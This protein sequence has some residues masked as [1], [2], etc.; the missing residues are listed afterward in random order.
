MCSFSSPRLLASLVSSSCS[1]LA[2]SFSSIPHPLSLFYSKV[3]L[4]PKECTTSSLA[5]DSVHSASPVPA[6]YSVQQLPLV[7]PQAG[8]VV[9]EYLWETSSLTTFLG[10]LESRF[11]AR[12][13][14]QIF[15]SM[16]HHNDFFIMAM[17]SPTGSGSQPSEGGFS[18]FLGNDLSLE[19]NTCSLYLFYFYILYSFL[20]LLLDNSP[21]YKCLLQFNIL[22]IK[23]PQQIT[24]WFLSPDWTLMDTKRNQGFQ[25]WDKEIR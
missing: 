18:S 1:A 22:Y 13:R 17:L 16:Q 23:Q 5:P 6:V 21:F 9:A 2:S 12:L 20:Y 10:F 7:F 3:L 24:K 8:D 19:V 11:L 15:S 14:G 25:I 4:A